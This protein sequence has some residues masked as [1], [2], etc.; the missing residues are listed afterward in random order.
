MTMPIQTYSRPRGT[1]SRC[2]YRHAMRRD[3]TM[4]KHWIYYGREGHVCPGAGLPDRY[5][6]GNTQA[7]VEYMQAREAASRP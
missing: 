5:A 1:C 2:G 7:L 3:G 6:A 4:A